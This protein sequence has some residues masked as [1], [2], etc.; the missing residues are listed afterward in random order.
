[1]VRQRSR[2]SAQYWITATSN[3]LDISI[4]EW[5]KLFADRKDPHHWENIVSDADEFERLMYKR[6]RVGA[7]YF[8][9]YSLAVRRYRDKFLAHLDSDFV[10]E[11]PKLDLAMSASCIYYAHV[12]DIE[13]APQTARSFPADLHEYYEANLNEARNVFLTYIEATTPASGPKG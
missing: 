11:I 6:L 12:R 7:A 8:E 10:M 13:C 2:I 4:L 3:S 1:M 9:A 5:C